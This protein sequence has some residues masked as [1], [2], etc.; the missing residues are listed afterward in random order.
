VSM[1]GGMAG[2][3][4]TGHFP[5]SQIMNRVQDRWY[6]HGRNKVSAT[7]KNRAFPE[8]RLCER[9]DGRWSFY[10]GDVLVAQGVNTE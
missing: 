3:E 1:Y 6:E 10:D 5:P 8:V 7:Y 2:N 4:A 9:F